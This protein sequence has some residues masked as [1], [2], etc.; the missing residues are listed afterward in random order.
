MKK[1][2][3]C[4]YVNDWEHCLLRMSE[5]NGEKPMASDF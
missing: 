2:L 3:L 4:L 1:S 5:A